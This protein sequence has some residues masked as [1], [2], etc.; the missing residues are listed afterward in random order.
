LFLKDGLLDE[1][2]HIRQQNEQQTTK[3]K[4]YLVKNLTLVTSDSV[5]A[6]RID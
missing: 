2:K 5:K 3:E 1:E 6:Q 4:I